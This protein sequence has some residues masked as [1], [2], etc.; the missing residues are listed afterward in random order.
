MNDVHRREQNI[1]S[2]VRLK[3][4]NSCWLRRIKCLREM[5]VECDT[6]N[7]KI[8]DLFLKL[9]DLTKE[10]EGPHLIMDS[11]LL[12]KDQLQEQLEALK[13][14][15]ASEF[16]NLTEFLE[17]EVEKWLIHYVNKNEDIEDTI[18]QLGFELKD[19]ENEL[20]DTKIKH[21]IM[22]PPMWEYIE[23]WLKNALVK[24]IEPNHQE[25]VTTIRAPPIEQHTKET[26][27]SK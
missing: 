23:Q 13:T 12:S 16:D 9:V 3:Q 14:S 24:V 17:E 22:V 6:I 4:I 26:S 7:S 8:S 11:I 1:P 15:W 25:A 19:I 10:L 2:K 18:H 20:F 21:E 27:T 5:L